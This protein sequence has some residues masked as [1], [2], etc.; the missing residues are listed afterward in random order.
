[1]VEDKY[2]SDYRTQK[3][4]NETYTYA[5]KMT[6][7]ELK[8]K[9]NKHYETKGNKEVIELGGYFWYPIQF[10]GKDGKLVQMIYRY[11]K[12]EQA[13]AK[14]AGSGGGG[15]KTFAPRKEYYKTYK[16][17][18]PVLATDYQTQ[19]ELEKKGFTVLTAELIGD[20]ALF[21]NDQGDMV[22]NYGIVYKIE[23]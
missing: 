2:S 11:L 14:A 18:T 22:Q 13:D 1:V 3:D 5:D 15:G 7:E 6:D 19:I 9:V 23:L 10:T 21:I 17:L 8:T 16:Q 12:K 4:T 20:K